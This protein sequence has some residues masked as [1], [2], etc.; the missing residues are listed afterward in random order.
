MPPSVSAGNGS[1]SVVS[2]SWLAPV[3]DYG[4]SVLCD[5]AAVGVVL[6]FEHLGYRPPTGM[7]MLAPVFISCWYGKA[8]PAALSVI[9]A[10]LYMNYFFV[11]P[12][13]SLDVSP[14]ELPYLLTYTFLA[15]LVW[16]FSTVRRRLE[17]DL[18]QTRDNLKIEVDERSSLLDLTNDSISIRT[19]DFMLTYWNRGAED[20][21]GWTRKEAIGKH[22][23]ELLRT[24]YPK[25]IDQILGELLENHKWEGELTR[26]KRDG[27]QVVVWSRWALRRDKQNRPIAIL[28]TSNDMTARKRWEEEIQALNREL[29]KKSLAL[30]TTNKELEAFAYS[31][32]HDLRA[33]LRHLAGFG[34]LLQKRPA[35]SEDDKS[36]HFMS[37][38]LESANRMGILIDELLA[39]SRVT[40]A[41]M[42]ISDIDLNQI[43]QEVVNEARQDADDRKIFWN[44]HRFPQLQGDREM[45]RV[46]LDNLISNAVK[47]TRLRTQAE[48]EI[49]TAGLKDDRLVVFVRDNGVGFDMKYYDQLFGVFQRLHP[50]ETFEG[51]GIGLATVQRIIN[52]HGGQVW[53]EAGVDRGATFYFTLFK[54][55]KLREFNDNGT[56]RTYSAG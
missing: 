14:A 41:D 36:K 27:A 8:G 12:R 15:M 52:R 38:I 2:P 10:V 47:F 17:K 44:I 46:V 26:T 23:Q 34:Q 16:W 50:R 20:C 24:I 22:P 48:I 4:F 9:L 55:L 40:R 32:S 1:R 25:P 18:R 5:S 42:K 11:E 3:L 6:F 31:V 21:Y 51:T 43:I 49:G 29:A 19:M 30:E 39:F 7:L 45:L 37:M 53:A 33:P 13:Y 28:E 54:N 35:V 56:L